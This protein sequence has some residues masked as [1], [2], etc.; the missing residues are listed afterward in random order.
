MVVWYIILLLAVLSLIFWQYIRAALARIRTYRFIKKVCVANK[1]DIKLMNGSYAVSKNKNDG[2]D[3]ILKIGNTVLPVKFYSAL[4]TRDTAYIDPRGRVCVRG[5]YR[6]PLSRSGRPEGQ[7]V[8]R[9]YALPSMK[10]RKDMISKN[11]TVY[12]VF[13]NEPAFKAV[14]LLDKAGKT[15]DIFDTNGVVAGCRWL[16]KDT[17]ISLIAAYVRK[18]KK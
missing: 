12:P 9:F 5:I 8:K 11:Y 3:F 16:D 13:L 18:N 6:K 7:A 17:L 2:F 4:S 1:I 15:T 14:K 10:I